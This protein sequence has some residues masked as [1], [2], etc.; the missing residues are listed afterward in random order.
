MMTWVVMMVMVLCGVTAQCLFP[1]LAMLGQAKPPFLLAIVL[2]YALNRTPNT[3]LLAG[4]L[5]GL[6]HDALTA[7]PLGYSSL[8]F[9]L[10]GLAAGRFRQLVLSESRVTAGFFGVVG[11]LVAHVALYAIL[12]HSGA[13]WWPLGRLTVRLLAGAG[14][15]ALATPLTFAAA[16]RF[17]QW[18]GNIE[19]REVI[20][21]IEQPIG[22]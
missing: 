4:L 12:A 3:V 22:R 16:H 8:I 5:A 10:V 6:A 19:V 7:V 20:D 18:V 13:V 15:A 9:V 21:G 2:Y 1:A 11:A 14:L 17:D